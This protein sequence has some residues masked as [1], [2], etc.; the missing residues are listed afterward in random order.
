M[1]TPYRID[2]RPR[3]SEIVSNPEFSAP[4]ISFPGPMSLVYLFKEDLL[5]L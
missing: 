5:C 3:K 4:E 2:T 1:L